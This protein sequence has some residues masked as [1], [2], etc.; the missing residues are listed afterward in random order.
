MRIFQ[1]SGGFAEPGLKFG[2]PDKAHVKKHDYHPA[3]PKHVQL[4]YFFDRL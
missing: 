2:F 3:R 1:A 4:L